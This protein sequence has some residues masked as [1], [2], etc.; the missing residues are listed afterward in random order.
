MFFISKI[1]NKCYHRIMAFIIQL[2]SILCAVISDYAQ[3]HI[4][5][6]MG[7]IFFRFNVRSHHFQILLSIAV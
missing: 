3:R 1:Q 6:G 5:I 7:L 4:R 2:R